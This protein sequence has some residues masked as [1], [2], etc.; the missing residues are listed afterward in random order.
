MKKKL[1][2]FCFIFSIAV[3]SGISILPDSIVT[4]AIF[5]GTLSFIFGLYISVSASKKKCKKVGKVR[6]LFHG[7]LTSL[8]AV[9]IFALLSYVDIL[10]KPAQIVIPNKKVAKYIGIFVYIFLALRWI[11]KRNY[12]SSVKKVCNLCYA[13]LVDNLK[14][15]NEYLDKAPE[16]IDTNIEIR[17]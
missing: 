4:R 7:G 10:N 5:L 11:T 1:S 14:K 9:S 8:I 15:Y 17:D 3:V 12:T 13:D 2:S 16:P 6:S